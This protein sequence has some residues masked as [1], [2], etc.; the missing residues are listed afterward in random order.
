MCSCYLLAEHLSCSI[1]SLR[2]RRMGDFLGNG[3]YVGR[4]AGGDLPLC[5]LV[6]LPTGASFWL[7]GQEGWVVAPPRASLGFW[8]VKG[9]SGKRKQSLARSRGSACAAFQAQLL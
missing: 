8:E 2:Q 5:A 9:M 3:S 4:D 7:K 6:L 1:V